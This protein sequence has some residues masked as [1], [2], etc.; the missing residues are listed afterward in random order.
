M[1]VLRQNRKPQIKWEKNTQEIQIE[2]K[3][4]DHGAVLEKNTSGT[5]IIRRIETRNVNIIH[6]WLKG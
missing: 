5:L 2:I 3:L 1:N 6:K 4:R